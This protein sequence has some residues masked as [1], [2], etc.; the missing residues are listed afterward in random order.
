MKN[1]KKLSR[2]DLK[3]L[4]GALRNDQIQPVGPSFDL[5]DTGGGSESG[6]GYY[7]CCSNNS[8]A[9]S[10]CVYIRTNP[11]CSTGSYAVSC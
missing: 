4:S 6:G 11:V 3:N 5:G 1:L 7:K 9:C 10:S 8:D 2:N